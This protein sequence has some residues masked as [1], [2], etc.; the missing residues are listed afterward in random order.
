MNNLELAKE[1]WKKAQSEF[2]EVQSQLVYTRKDLEEA[3][4][5]FYRVFA[6]SKGLIAGE[7][8]L[9]F[10]GEYK[11]IFSSIDRIYTDNDFSINVFD[12]DENG[13][14][15]LQEQYGGEIEFYTREP[16]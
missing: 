13:K 11:F 8:E 12:I 2:D 5:N 4:K 15:N 3:K 14:I 7:T 16:K 6:K 10:T 1:Q 9:Y